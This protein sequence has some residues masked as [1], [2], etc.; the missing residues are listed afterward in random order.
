MQNK[1]N[2]K[3]KRAYFDYEILEKLSAGMVL[4]GTEV[5]SI[6]NGKV[7]LGDSYCFIREGEMFIRGMQ[8]AEYKFGTYN[9]HS[10][11]RER[12]LL[13]LRKEIKRMDRKT[14]ETGNTIVPL[15]IYFSNSGY[16]KIDLALAKGK[17]QYDKR[18]SIKQK[19][20]KRQM[21]RLHKY[22]ER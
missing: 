20:A 10:P 11:E 19:D 21:D 5:K 8:I 22:K 2:I 7:S 15:R 14:R 1:I 13:L 17:K 3:N 12:K 18:E 16:A 6:R 9:N 4:T